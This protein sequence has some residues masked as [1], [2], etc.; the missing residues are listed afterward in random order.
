[1]ADEK[2]LDSLSLDDLEYTMLVDNPSGILVV[3]DEDVIRMVFDALLAEAG[4][5]VQYA[6]TAEKAI[7]R[8][9]RDDQLNLL[10]VDKNLPGQSGLD[11]MRQVHDVRPDTGFIMITGYASYESA[12]EALR[13][14]AYDYLEKPFSDLVLVREKI[15]RALDRQR[16]LRENQ[17]L[18]HQL[19][20]VHKDL[21]SKVATLALRGTG[22]DP[23]L[24][25]HVEQLKD[26][27]G[28][29]ARALQDAYT[30]Y[31]ALMDNQLVPKEPG[32]T[33]RELLQTSWAELSAA[34]ADDETGSTH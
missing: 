11:L 20:S 23:R 1:M 15:D 25:A 3:D 27:V 6:D 5:Q 29:A 28:R 31:A 17:V 19:R 26:R 24:A 14:G 34:M 30:R 13:L 9:Q 33:I 10:I 12:V 16:L 22:A 18:A 2:G 21:R 8:V 4:Y 7:D 32:E